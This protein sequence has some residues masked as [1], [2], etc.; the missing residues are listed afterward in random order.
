MRRRGGG[1][2]ADVGSVMVRLDDL[3]TELNDR[4]NELADTERQLEPVEA[5]YEDEVGDW[6]SGL[7]DECLTSDTKWPPERLRQRL[8]HK[9]IDQDLLGLHRTLTARRKRLEKRIASIKTQVD[10]QRS[11]LSALKEEMSATR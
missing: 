3:S 10:A 5:R 11:I 1:M 9:Q 6:E 7:W 8:A 4:S 2:S